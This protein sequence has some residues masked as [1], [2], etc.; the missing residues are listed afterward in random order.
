MH[1]YR[2]PKV[3]DKLYAALKDGNLPTSVIQQLS[4]GHDISYLAMNINKQHRTIV[5][6]QPDILKIL[7]KS[8]N[9]T[10]SIRHRMMTS[11][12][13]VCALSTKCREPNEAEKIIQSYRI[14]R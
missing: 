13:I 8:I 5:L 14:S 9:Q 4:H 11:Y 12:S 1:I 10:N 7:S 2:G 6:S 3:L